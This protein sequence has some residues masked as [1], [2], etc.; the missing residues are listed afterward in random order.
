VPIPPIDS[1]RKDYVGSWS[2]PVIAKVGARDHLVL[3]V[4][5][6]LKGFDPATGRELWTCDGLSNLVYGSPLVSNGIAVAMSGFSGNALAVRLGGAGDI[7]KDRLWHHTKGNPQ[8]IGTGV[9]VGEHLYTVEEPGTPRCFEVRTGNE[10]WGA[11]VEKRP[12][13]AVWGSMLHADGRLYVT[14]RNGTTLVMAANPKFELLASN[15]LGEHTD[16][17]IA[18]S[19]GDLFIRT[20]KSLWC[21]SEKK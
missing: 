1:A 10:V 20:Y 3:G 11:Q 4:P 6:K 2:T 18:V 19:N 8:R 12:G 15:R 21:I 7:T 13:G 9:V 14:D 16:A 17:S 5:T